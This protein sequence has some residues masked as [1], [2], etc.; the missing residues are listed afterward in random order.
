M[1]T[2]SDKEI[3]KSYVI[4]KFKENQLNDVS[5]DIQD[6]DRESNIEKVR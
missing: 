2:S 6:E 1:P 4:A 3:V 5:D